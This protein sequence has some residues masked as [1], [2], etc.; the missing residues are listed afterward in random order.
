MGRPPKPD[1]TSE[2]VDLAHKMREAGSGWQ[3]IA[4]A[5][6]EGRDAHKA[7]TKEVRT[8]R[9]VSARW[10]QRRIF[11]KIETSAKQQDPRRLGNLRQNQ[12]STA[13]TGPRIARGPS[14]EEIEDHFLQSQKAKDGQAQAKVEVASG[15]SKA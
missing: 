6:T 2:E 14:L 11:G 10:V 13:Y 15:G 7:A 5:I 3:S 4:A 8:K 1:P 12:K 9:T